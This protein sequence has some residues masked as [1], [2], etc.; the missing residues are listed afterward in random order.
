M[1]EILCHDKINTR[2][3]FWTVF[4]PVTTFS[5]KQTY[6]QHVEFCKCFLPVEIVSELHRL[7]L[8]RYMTTHL[9]AKGA[10]MSGKVEV[11]QSHLRKLQNVTL[12]HNH[13][14]SIQ[15]EGSLHSRSSKSKQSFVSIC[16]F[17]SVVIS[18]LL[19]LQIKN[20]I[21]KMSP[22]ACFA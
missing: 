16:Y 1:L 10:L 3:N 17:Q 9:K 22:L 6:I 7:H 14:S 18:V 13:P 15:Y 2:K 5:N 8:Q 20:A 12:A 4:Q 19:Q 21:S 11:F